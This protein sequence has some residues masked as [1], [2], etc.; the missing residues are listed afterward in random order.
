MYPADESS[1]SGDF[2]CGG[3]ENIKIQ[4]FKQSVKT[5]VG[6]YETMCRLRCM[7]SAG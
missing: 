7:E 3:S 6:V 5:G 2:Y 4:A 1:A